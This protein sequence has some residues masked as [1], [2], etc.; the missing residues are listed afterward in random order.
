MHRLADPYGR[1]NQ[2]QLVGVLDLAHAAQVRL[3]VPHI[4]RRRGNRGW[5]RGVLDP[6][7]L[8]PEF[9]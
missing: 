8:A 2:L 6:D 3:N 1:A 4:P 7:N 5:Q 9:P